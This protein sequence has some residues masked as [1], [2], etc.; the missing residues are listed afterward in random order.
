MSSPK[1]FDS[2]I[3]EIEAQTKDLPDYVSYF[4]SLKRKEKPEN[5]IFCGS[6]DSLACALFVERVT[7]FRARAM[8]P[9]DLIICP[10][11]A[12][13]KSVYFVSVSGKTL[14]NI[15]AARIIKRYDPRKTIA[16]TANPGSLL[17]KSCSE[18]IELKFA[19]SPSITPGT[20]S[21]T[22]S[23]LACSLLFNKA[24]R[25][26]V[27]QMIENAKE[28]AKG[29]GNAYNGTYH[30][31]GSGPFFALALYG[32]A[33]LFEF[34]RE[35]ATYQLIEQFSHL[36]L[37]SIDRE[38]D[39]VFILRSKLDEEKAKFL[40]ANLT[41]AGVRSYLLPMEAKRHSSIELAIS[42]AIHLQ[43][44]ALEVAQKRGL[45]EP[46]FLK[47]KEILMVSDSMIY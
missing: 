29:S 41:Q 30:F 7:E 19:K 20:N 27:G 32:A 15:R 43:F 42:Y 18:T 38:K 14:T 36:N 23:L 40:D 10:K 5:A 12:R 35:R 17:V 22:T 46:A 16:V 45:D 13:G 39:S 37:F 25:L 24:P 44:L 3:K 34:A 31:V 28:W 11:I 2:T 9:Y 4:E 6:G 1:S 47:D 8:D 21:F 33:K 26:E